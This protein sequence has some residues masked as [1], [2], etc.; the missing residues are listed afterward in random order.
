MDLEAV[1]PG[2]LAGS[3]NFRVVDQCRVGQPVQALTPV[4]IRRYENIDKG[5]L[6]ILGSIAF[7][8]RKEVVEE[9]TAVFGREDSVNFAT[10]DI[11]L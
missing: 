2:D 11:Q 8:F 6:P 9:R 7:R 10:F 5:L 3:D 4:G 1:I